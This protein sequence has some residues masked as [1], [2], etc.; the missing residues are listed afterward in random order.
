[1]AKRK[2]PSLPSREKAQKRPLP[3]AWKPGQSGNP[4]GRKPGR[5]PFVEAIRR[6]VDDET[7]EMLTGRLIASAKAGSLG[8]ATF[9]MRH[10]PKHATALLPDGT[11]IE[12]TADAGK[13]MTKIAE[14]MTN[15]ELSIEEASAAIA[16]IGTVLAG[17]AGSSGLDDLMKRVAELK[18]VAERRV[19]AA[20][21][22][23]LPWESQADAPPPTDSK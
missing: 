3:Q 23:P 16:A 6:R 7:A 13:A 18:A 17:V 8:A 20:D 21:G 10:L 2:P 15:G 11:K 14:Q 9:I 22:P 1:M 4:A 12:T 5:N 19:A